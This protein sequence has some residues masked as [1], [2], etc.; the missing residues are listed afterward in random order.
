VE[1]FIQEFSGS[2]RIVAEYLLAEVLDQQTPEVRRLLVRASVLDRVNGALGDLLT[3]STGSEGALSALAEDGSF[4]VPVDGTGEWFRFHHLFGDLLAAELR[5]SEPSAIA[6][7][8]QS[9][10]GWYAEHGYVL[11]AIR[12]SLAADDRERVVTLLVDQYLG[13]MLDGRQVTARELL[14]A[15]VARDDS[16]E[17]VVLLA[18]DELIAGS[19]DTAAA[20]LRL[21]EHKRREVPADRLE[22]FEMMLSLCRLTLA[23]RVGDFHA[24]PEATSDDSRCSEPQ[25]ER[26]L[27]TQID[28]RAWLL[29][30]R[31]IVEVWSGMLVEGEQHLLEAGEM[32]RHANRPY[33]VASCV[34][35]RAQAI[36]WRSFTEA[37]PVAR[38]ALAIVEA[39]GLRDDPI[40]GVAHLVEG[41]CL[42]ASG[43]LGGADEAF[44]HAD[45]TLRSDLEPAVGLMLET[46]HGVVHLLKRRYS[47]A[48]ER[49]LRA[50]RLGRSLTVSA[51]LALQAS[52]AGMYAA[53]L[54]GDDHYVQ[55]A[56]DRLTDAERNTGEVREVV[57]ARAIASGDAAAAIDS[58]TPILAGT[59]PMHHEMVLIRSL[60]LDAKA[61]DMLGDATTARN[62]V[63]RALELAEG[64]GLIDPFLWV[65]CIQL[66]ERHQHD[67][68]T[69]RLFLGA[70][71]TAIHEVSG[72]EIGVT[73]ET[74]G[75]FAGELSETERRVLRYLPTNLTAPEIAAEVFLSVNT[76]KTHMRSIY[77]KLDAHS[78]T[79]AVQSA[80]DRGLLGATTPATAARPL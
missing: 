27:A 47:E 70:I 64:D 59:I 16:A 33:L 54:G 39:A 21:A 19:L 55:K 11:E 10:A 28:L 43:R 58:L 34:A 8:H 46:G 42:V 1:R 76:I 7:L 75:A 6:G 20:Q 62:S 80:R 36:S 22:R 15:A 9:A 2:E 18:A 78:R 25:S 31:G 38:E 41:I 12:H 52:C 66:L 67:R 26:E 73:P 69:H 14:D 3:G 71:L 50:E 74:P 30:N 44:R 48:T 53:I 72:G 17:L 79:Q 65:E 5:H 32:A 23:R 56:L 68:T 24:I 4:V 29:M 63:E 77:A 60:L 45:R 61:H 37:L 57:A 49:F 40:A 35:H 51:P 13:L